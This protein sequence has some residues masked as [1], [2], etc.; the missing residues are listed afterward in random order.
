[1]HPFSHRLAGFIALALW[2]GLALTLTMGQTAT[3]APHLPTTPY[4]TTITVDSS[5]DVTTSLSERCDTHTPCT[6]RRAIVQARLLAPE[7]RPVLIQFNIPTEDVGYNAS[8]QVWEL[9]VKSTSDPAVFRTIEGGQI[10]IDGTT[11]PNGR[12]TGP[13]IILVGPSTG[14]KNGLIVG[15]NSAGGHDGNTIR[16]LG[17]QNFKDHITINSNN[18]T[19]E[20]NWFGLTSNGQLPY[21]RNNNAQ[22]GS[23]SGGLVFIS[24]CTGNVAQHN[25]F[26]GFDGVA[27]ALRGNGNTVRQNWVGTNASGLV[28]GKQTDPSLLCT[29]E[30]WLGGGGFSLDGP[31]HIVEQNRLAGLRQEIFTISTQ[32]DA[33]WVQ[34]TCTGCIIANNEIGID[35][36]GHEVGVCG[37]GFDLTNTKQVQVVDNILAETYNSALFLNGATYDANT[38]R[39]NIIR[40]STPWL[41]PQSSPKGDDAILRFTG[42]PDPL[43]FFNPA[44]VTN[45]NGTAVSGT[46]GENSPCPN[47]IIELFLDDNDG[48]NEA[49]ESLAVVTAAGDG[50]WSATLAA[51]LPTGFG[52]RTTSTTAQFNTISNISKDTT[53]GL[54]VL[55]GI[56]YDIY[57]PL[58][59]K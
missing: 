23:G 37:I 54:S 4:A 38:L 25:I 6:L 30:D 42:L 12:A 57:L 56:G 53:V 48:I 3:A 31:N 19:I 1:M 17:F 9:E 39:G 28:P 34:S 14:N 18:N 35:E 21:L 46:A 15:V 58:V 22:D 49:L 50:T 24:G 33:M 27:I 43:E 36:G 2:G 26:L 45:I 32:P 52:I 44:K 29:T 40:R 55:Y 47:C 5:R 41:V 7:A 13:K 10:T 51:P 16:G 11:Q 20:H 59:V 8:L